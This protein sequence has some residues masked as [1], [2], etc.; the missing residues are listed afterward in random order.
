VRDQSFGGMVRKCYFGFGNKG[1]NEQYRENG[2]AG[3]ITSLKEN[4][5]FML[6]ALI[7]EWTSGVNAYLAKKEDTIAR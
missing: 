6:L 7:L 1:H 2:E 5:T 4:S 3:V